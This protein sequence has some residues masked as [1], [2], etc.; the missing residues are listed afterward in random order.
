M[1]SNRYPIRQVREHPLEPL[2][3]KTWPA[4]LPPVA[5]LLDSG[6]DLAP[7]TVFVGENGSG[8]STLVEAVALA[9]GLSPEGGSTGARHTTRSTESVLSEHLQLVRN[10]GGTKRG[11]FLRAET[12]HGFFTYLEKNPSTSRM[13]TEFHS[14]SHGES[15]LSLAVDRFR[16]PGLW[17]LDEPESALSFSGCLALLGLLKDLVADGRSQVLLSTHSPLLAALPGARILEL[18]PWGFREKQ[19]EDLDLVSSWQG[20]F[21]APERYLRRL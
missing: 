18:G 7:A 9:F 3:R 1:L 15:F 21:D 13:D 19:W 17:V 4:T 11:Y 10:P 8:K 6:L 2:E 5:Q 12:M 14:L 16:G 20:F